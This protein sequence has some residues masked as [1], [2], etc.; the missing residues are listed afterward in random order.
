MNCIKKEPVCLFNWYLIHRISKQ[1]LCFK[2]SESEGGYGM[3][4]LH[5]S[6]K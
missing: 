6:S 2:G 3:I 5:Y 4:S 1:F